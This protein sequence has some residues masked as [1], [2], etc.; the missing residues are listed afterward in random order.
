MKFIA[1]KCPCC[2]GKIEFENNK[3]IYHCEYCNNDIIFDDG[4]LINN[5][6]EKSLTHE[7]YK[8]TIEDFKSYQKINKMVFLIIVPF[9]L[10]IIGIVAYI[11]FNSFNMMSKPDDRRT[12]SNMFNVQIQQIGNINGLA[13]G[14]ILDSVV[15]NINEYSINVSVI[16]DKEYIEIKEIS[17]LASKFK[18]DAHTEYF[19][20]NEKDSN[21]YITKIIIEN[22]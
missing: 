9:V 20:S 12:N 21:G 10:A 3:K 16:Y 14:S 19:V 7:L 4:S 15:N 11:L 5:E 1:A 13:I 17:S 18:D 8:L 22:I 2:G 6:S